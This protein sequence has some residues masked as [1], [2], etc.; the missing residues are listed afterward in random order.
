MNKTKK[1]AALAAVALLT[2]ASVTAGSLFDSPAAL[3][4][5]DGASAVVY[6]INTGTD[7][8]DDD[9]AGPEQDESE[10]TRRRGGLRMILR[11]RILQLPLI[12]RLLILLPLWAVGTILIAASGTAWS[13]LSPVLGKAAGF[14]L[15]SALLIGA[16]AIAAKAVFPDLP[17]K[18]LLSRRSF[19]ALILGAALLSLLDAIL[20]AAWGGYERY[21]NIILSAGFFLSASCVTVPFALR[22]QQRRLRAVKEAAERR[23]KPETLT[24]TD[25]G[26]TFTVTI[27]NITGS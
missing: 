13:L 4:S 17:V 9:D 18:K 20:G 24:F 3:L 12:V 26:G 5:D 15:L 22:E 27:P 2:A 6:Q 19:V 16:F 25:A 14:A 23:K 8:A 21:K 11:M 10:E 7:G 1:K